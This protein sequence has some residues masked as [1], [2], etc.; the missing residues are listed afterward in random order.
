MLRHCLGREFVSTLFEDV[1]RPLPEGLGHDQKQV[2]PLLRETND[3]GRPNPLPL[4]RAFREDRRQASW[5]TN[6]G[7]LFLFRSPCLF[8]QDR[9]V[10]LTT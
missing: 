7:T 8:L 3:G 2:V 1:L 5:Q 9:L 4:G 10:V 6:E